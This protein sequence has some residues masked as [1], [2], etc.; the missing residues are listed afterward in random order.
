LHM[1]ASGTPL[2]LSPAPMKSAAEASATNAKSKVYS[3]RS[4]PCSIIAAVIY[5]RNRAQR[6][7]HAA[8]H[9]RGRS[10]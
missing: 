5:F 4:W 7:S 10:W 6:N 3:I 2:T 9:Q 8:G 1:T